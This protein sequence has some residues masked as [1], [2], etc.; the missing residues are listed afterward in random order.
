MNQLFF[1]IRF[2]FIHIYISI[3]MTLFISI[4]KFRK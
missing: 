1:G 4:I 3:G 2:L